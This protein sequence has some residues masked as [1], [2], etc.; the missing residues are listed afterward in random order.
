MSFVS[1]T[2]E[3]LPEA[4]WPEG[5]TNVAAGR[6]EA[7][8]YVV[9]AILSPEGGDAAPVASSQVSSPSLSFIRYWILQKLGL[10]AKPG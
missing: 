3:K 7:G 10:G 1:S 9:G 8:M 6:L 5:T 4:P 2:N